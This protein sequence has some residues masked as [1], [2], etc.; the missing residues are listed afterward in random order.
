[1]NE[2]SLRLKV[3]KKI[4]NILK[5]KY[6]KLHFFILLFSKVKEKFRTQKPWIFFVYNNNQRLSIIKL[7]NN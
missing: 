1:M 2:L 3:N 4:N 5:M 6:K 7:D